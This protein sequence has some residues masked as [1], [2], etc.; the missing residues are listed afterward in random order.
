MNCREFRRK[1]DAYI[2]DTLSGVELDAMARHR[3]LCDDCARL[4]TRVRRAL[5]VAHN[6][7]TIEPS[8]EFA[9]RLQIRLTEER[10]RMAALHVSE[11]VGWRWRPSSPGGYAAMAAGLITVAGLAATLSGIGREPEMIRLAP[12]VATLPELEPSM[13]ASPAM[14]ASMPTGLTVWPALYVAQQAPWHFASD[15][16]GR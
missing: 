9:E 6:L 5:L 12:V 7:P 3:S 11:T 4:D 15:A 1:H 8:A 16:V 14:V 10:T 13:F 2:D